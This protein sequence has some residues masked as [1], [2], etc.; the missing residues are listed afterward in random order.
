MIAPTDYE[1]LRQLLLKRSGLALGGDKQYLLD[2]RLAPVMRQHGLASMA[3]LAL[4][5]RAPNNQSLERSVVEAMTTNESFFFRDKTPFENF[6][7][8]I[9]PKLLATRAPGKTIRIWCAAASTGQEPYSLAILIKENGAKLAGWRFEIIGTDLSQEVL[10]RAATGIYSQFEVQRGLSIQHLVKHFAKTGDS[11]QISPNLRAMVQFKPLNLLQP[12]THLGMFDVI[13]CRNVLIY[14]DAPT[15]SD[16]MTRLAKVL[17][18]DGYLILGGAETVMGL[19]DAFR[20]DPGQR[21]LYVQNHAA[22]LDP[23]ATVP[24]RVAAM[25]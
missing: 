15:K 14:F 25:R 2:G 21:S 3:E 12:F 5:L 7:T 1:F 6:T 4:K 11:W 17:T 22:A 8:V 20:L 18:P 23:R 19:S 24:S 10:D 16:V 9:L 13:F